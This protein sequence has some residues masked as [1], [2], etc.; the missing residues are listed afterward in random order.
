VTKKARLKQSI[1]MNWKAWDN[2]AAACGLPSR[3][4]LALNV[5]VHI[6]VYLRNHKNHFMKVT[7]LILAAIAITISVSAFSQDTTGRNKRDTTTRRDS[8]TSTWGNYPPTQSQSGT[9]VTGQETQT[10]T[11]ATTQ[12]NFP[13]P[14]FGNYYIPVLGTYTAA[15]TSATT[16]SERTITITGDEKNVGKVWIEGLTSAKVYALLKAVPG[17]YKIPAQKQDEKQIQE[18]T[19]IYDE[20]NKT[21]NVCLG[22]GYKDQNPADVLA[23]IESG[24][25]K[26]TKSVLMFT[27]T[28]TDQGTVSNH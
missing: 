7:R 21:I 28:K 25:R 11:E 19:L 15:N 1:D 9:A 8:I 14:N 10:E 23:N 12:Q 3:L 22:C 20:A 5:C 26:N 6:Q 24:N 17:T 16:N 4:L 18:G 27:G 13:A 2:N